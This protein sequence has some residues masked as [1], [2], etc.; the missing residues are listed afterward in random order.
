MSPAPDSPDAYAHALHPLATPPAGPA[1]NF[2]ELAD[3]LP[4]A[5]PAG[6]VARGCSAR[7]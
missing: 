3:L 1:W 5:G 6:G 7:A 2:A 4:D